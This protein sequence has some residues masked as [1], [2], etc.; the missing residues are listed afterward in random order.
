MVGSAGVF[1]NPGSDSNKIL[2]FILEIKENLTT[3]NISKLVETAN[4]ADYIKLLRGYICSRVQ[5]D[6]K[7]ALE[8]Y[9]QAIPAYPYTGFA[10][11]SK[12]RNSG[13]AR[14]LL[15]K[16]EPSKRYHQDQS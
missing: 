8:I 2:Y 11:K 3:R 4:V 10:P 6:Y 1:V 5:S 13:A 14:L 7:P 9:V 15:S 12:N 16:F